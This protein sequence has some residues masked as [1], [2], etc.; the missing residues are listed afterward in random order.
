LEKCRAFEG[1]IMAKGKGLDTTSLMT[2]AAKS[3][4]TSI[5]NTAKQKCGVVG[6]FSGGGLSVVTQASVAESAGSTPERVLESIL[7]LDLAAFVF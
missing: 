6:R 5:G 1:I 4:D 2:L 3:S 7:A